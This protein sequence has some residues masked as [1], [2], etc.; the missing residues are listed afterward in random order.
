M[1]YLL[2]LLTLPLFVLAETKNCD[3]K[4]TLPAFRE[5]TQKIQNYTFEECFNIQDPPLNYI[6]KFKTK[7]SNITGNAQLTIWPDQHDTSSSASSLKKYLMELKKEKVTTLF[8]EMLPSDITID[9]NSPFPKDLESMLAKHIKGQWPTTHYYSLIKEA[10]KL[11]FRIEGY[12]PTKKDEEDHWHNKKLRST[13]NR[14][15]QM[16]TLNIL[17]KIK[18]Q[19]KVVILTGLAHANPYYENNDIKNNQRMLGEFLFQGIKEEDINIIIL[20]TKNFTQDVAKHSSFKKD[21]ILPLPTGKRPGCD[22]IESYSY[23]QKFLH[24]AD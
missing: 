18:G 4:K 16:Y 12:F 20:D 13:M 6:N 10:H 2:L 21:F 17:K 23:A 24:I 1:R 11:K 15:D 8:I 7:V 14:S 5:I 22:E 9:P 19:E 3:S